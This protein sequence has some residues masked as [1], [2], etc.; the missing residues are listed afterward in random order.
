LPLAATATV[1]RQV[2][3]STTLIPTPT[4][5]FSIL[6]TDTTLESGVVGE[7]Y[8]D[9]VQAKTLLGKK[10]TGDAVS[11]SLTGS[12]PAGLSFN[13]SSGI[14]LGT[15]SIKESPGNFK[16]LV[17][18]Y[19]GNY[20]T[21]TYLFDLAVLAKPRAPAMILMNTVW[22]ESGKSIL[23]SASKI[24]LNKM[25]AKL[26][27]AKYKTVVIN[28]FTDGVSGQ[29]HQVLSQARSDVVKRYLLAKT[30]GIKVNSSGKGLAPSSKH[31][32]KATQLSRK[33]EIWVG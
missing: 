15:I 26:K 29:S 30:N 33:A 12:L 14:V 11:Y 4:E 24:S 20:P 17:S 23:S 19:S 1:I 5:N 9:Y 27:V 22:F 28:G 32:G 8:S 21:Q 3:I 2:P 13:S 7:P 16:L 18:A 31:S 25:V 6:F 10:F